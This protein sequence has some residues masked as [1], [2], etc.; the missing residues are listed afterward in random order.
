MSLN[1]ETLAKGDP[2]RVAFRQ[3]LWRFCGI[4]Y[5]GAGELMAELVGPFTKGKHPRTPL[6]RLFPFAELRPARGASRRD[7]ESAE[8][9]KLSEIAKGRKR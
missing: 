9:T 8:L 3:G 7:V 2:V 1:P 6:Q 5:S 4:R